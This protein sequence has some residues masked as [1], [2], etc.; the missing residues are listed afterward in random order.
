MD[1]HKE[2]EIGGGGVA[3]RD[4]LKTIIKLKRELKMVRME[5]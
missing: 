1:K 5:K 3:K 4:K 2:N